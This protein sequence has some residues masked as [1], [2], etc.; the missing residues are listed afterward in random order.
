MTLPLQIQGWRASRAPSHGARAAGPRRPDRLRGQVPVAAVGRHAAARVDR[1]RAGLRAQAA[2]D[3]RALRRARRDHPRPPE[4]AA[5][6][7]VAA[8]AAHGG[9]RHPLDRRS[10][11]PVDP[12]RRD[13]AAAGAHRRGDRLDAAGRSARWS[14]AIRRSSS[15]W[16]TRCARRLRAMATMHAWRPAARPQLRRQRLRACCRCS[17]CWLRCCCSGTSPRWPE[18]AAARSSGCCADRPGWTWPNCCRHLAMERPVL[19]APHQVALDLWPS[20]VDW[21][22]DSPRNLLYHAASRPRPRWWASCWARC[23]AWCWRC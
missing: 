14:C 12:H 2:D 1:P 17:P 19:P 4:R 15:R 9:V 16:R 3:G 21:P 13:V 6:A 11:V 5:A 22:L 18:R 10:G 23:W 7:A 8:R 20:L